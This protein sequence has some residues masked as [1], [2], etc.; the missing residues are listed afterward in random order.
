MQPGRKGSAAVAVKFSTTS[1]LVRLGTTSS[2]PGST[3]G[4]SSVAAFQLLL[5]SAPSMP[6]PGQM[7]LAA[8]ACRNFGSRSLLRSAGQSVPRTRSIQASAF[9]RAASRAQFTAAS[10]S[11]LHGFAH[12]GV[13]HHLAGHLF[14]P[15]Q[16]EVL[17]D[18]QGHRDEPRKARYCRPPLATEWCRE[19]CR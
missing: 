8:A 14:D 10:A 17:E 11:V 13:E 19:T 5:T 16:H 3:R 4:E 9:M 12:A 2:E 1:V 6:T 18:L 7:L 15:L